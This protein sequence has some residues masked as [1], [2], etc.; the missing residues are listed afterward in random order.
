[1]LHQVAKTRPVE[2]GSDYGDGTCIPLQATVVTRWFPDSDAMVSLPIEAMAVGFDMAASF[3]ETTRAIVGHSMLEP[4]VAFVGDD[5]IPETIGQCVPWVRAAA[6]PPGTPIAIAIDGGGRMW[7]QTLE[8]AMLT[9]YDGVDPIGQVELSRTSVV[10]TGHELFH[11]PTSSLLACVSCHPEGG[12]DGLVWDLPGLGLRR[13]M[14]LRGGLQGTEPLH[15]T[16]DLPTMIDLVEEVRHERMRGPKLDDDYAAALEHWLFAL[17]A[18][19][20]PPTDP[21][22]VAEGEVLFVDAGCATCHTGPQLTNAVTVPLP[23]SIPLQVPRLRGVGL[24]PPYMH[25][26]RAPDLTSATAEMLTISSPTITV[27]PDEIDRIVEF[28]RAQ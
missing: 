2:V 4:A 22:E 13:T 6:T 15:W 28:L 9:V 23:W 17:P 3:D 10:D 7:V 19:S 1:M 14:D 20:P 18:A 12:E 26:G 5:D 11:E 8:P 21:D 16:G 25:D 24:R 27:G